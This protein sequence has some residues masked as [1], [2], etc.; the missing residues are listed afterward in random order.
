M[1]EKR[2]RLAKYGV[3]T[4]TDGNPLLEGVVQPVTMLVP[5]LGRLIVPINTGS[6]SKNGM[7]KGPGNGCN[8][9]PI[10]PLT[11]DYAALKSNVNSLVAAGTT[12]I[13]EG[14]AWGN[15]VRGHDQQQSRPHHG[16]AERRLERFRQ[17]RQRPRLQLFQP[18]LSGGRT[19]WHR[20]R[21]IVGYQHADERAYAGRLQGR[22]GRR[23]RGLYHPASKNP[24]WPR[25]PCSRNAPAIR[26]NISTCR[27]A[28]SST[29][30]SA[31]S[32][33][34]SSR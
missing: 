18:G 3:A 27:T 30:P 8:V 5:Y 26:T 19:P 4:D 33:I 2:K 10:T 7:P 34:A 24:T 31:R 1:A 16:G 6:S 29:S 23:H 13:M 20:R 11:N 21:W 12:N 9:A 32:A 15:R 14:V 22:Q 28:P 25:A 17:H